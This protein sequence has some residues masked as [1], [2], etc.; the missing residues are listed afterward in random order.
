MTDSVRSGSVDPDRTL[1][2]VLR[3]SQAIGFIGPGPLAP[4]VAQAEA[5]AS[6]FDGSP[7]RVLDLGSGGG[8]PGLVLAATCWPET[9]LCLLDAGEQRAAFLRRAVDA[10]AFGGRVTVQRGRAELLARDARLRG[11]FDGVVARSFGPPAAVAECAVG[12]LRPGGVLVV[13]EP[14]AAGDGSDRWAFDDGLA[15]LELARDGVIEA[16]GARFQRLRAVAPCPDR[17]PRR[18]G[19]PLKRPLFG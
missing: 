9:E 12:F 7:E 3:E 16:A 8:L 13:S 10:L 14:P 19:V 4:H 5:F 17:Y 1:L 18:D 6:A 15:L 11:S 2:D